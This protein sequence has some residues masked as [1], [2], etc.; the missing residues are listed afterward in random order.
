LLPDFDQSLIEIRR[1][2]AFAASCDQ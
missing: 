1:E 2:R